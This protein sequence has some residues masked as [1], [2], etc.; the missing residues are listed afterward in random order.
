M[1]E[2]SNFASAKDRCLEVKLGLI[3]HVCG[4]IYQSTS[5]ILYRLQFRGKIPQGNQEET[6]GSILAAKF[7]M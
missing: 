4:R 6:E 5:S 1:P 3:Y 7:N 2:T